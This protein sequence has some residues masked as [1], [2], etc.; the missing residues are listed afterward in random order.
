MKKVNK[1]SIGFTIIELLVVV[2][3][4]GVISTMLVVNWRQGE[5]QYLLQ[6]TAQEMVQNIRKA[7]DMALTSSRHECEIPDNYGVYFTTQSP[8]SYKIFADKND[9]NQYDGADSDVENIDIES[10]IEISALSSEP[11]LHLTFSLP[12]AFVYI[13]PSA[14]SATITIKRTGLSCPDYCKE[15]KIMDTGRITIID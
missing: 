6:R 8:G 12:D 7:Q 4:I 14:T 3:V 10:G 1:N 13:S 15:I 5:K 9:N 2:A 11:K